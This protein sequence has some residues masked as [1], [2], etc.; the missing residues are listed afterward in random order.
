MRKRV[1]YAGAWLLAVVVA[2]AVGL[3]AVSTVGASV[4]GR[5]PLGGDVGGTVSSLETGPVSVDPK[6]S[7]VE[8]AI[9]GDWGTFLV[10]CRGVYAVGLRATPAAGWR[11]VSFEEGPDDDVDAVF[12]SGGRSVDLEIYCN[13]GRPTVGDEEHNTLPEDED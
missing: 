7:T 9:K 12:S 5:G 10:Q 4:R 2:T 3:A 13:R 1:G 8:R 11:V 6:A